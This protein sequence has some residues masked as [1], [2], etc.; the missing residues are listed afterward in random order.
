MAL[1]L[2]R[3]MLCAFLSGLL[4]TAAFPSGRLEWLAWIALIPLI[5]ALDGT[6]P[7]QAFRL[8][9][10]AGFIHFL[11]LIY[12]I[13]VVMGQYGGLPLP[14]SVSILVLLCLVL[15]LY[16]GFFACLA[17]PLIGTRFFPFG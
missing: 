6:T 12:W 11:T 14:V 5:K 15:S 7:L 9:F 16:P 13:V 4:L 1:F 10:M 2:D 3:K 8:G 17:S